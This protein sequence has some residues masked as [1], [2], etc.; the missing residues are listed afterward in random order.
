MR[1]APVYALVGHPVGHSLSPLLHGLMLRLSGRPGT[2]VALDSAE[3][4]G[5]AVVGA[6]R[7][8]GFAG[9]N[10]TIPLKEGA[11]PVVDRRAPSAAR[12]GATNTLV[13]DDK[14]LITAYNTDG[15]G[16]CDA[17]A[18]AGPLPARAA[19]LGAG[20]AARGVAAALGA[21]GVA[22]TLCNRDL[23]RAARAAAALGCAAAP[24]WGE[25]PP[26]EVELVVNCSAD[27][28]LVAEPERGAC[29]LV[30]GGLWVDTNYFR[31]PLG[32]PALVAA[33][34]R[35]QTGHP[36]LL[37][38]ARRAFALLTGG[39]APTAAALRAALVG[40]AWPTDGRG[41]PL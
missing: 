7:T 6:L 40:T 24:S 12:A 23:D 31:A 26:L 41:A 39:P 4:D 8:L 9:A 21:A 22:V 37:H 10:L 35:L 3:A 29:R 32:G 34:R 2:Y 13:I 14:Q 1:P 20:G 18:E 19:V 38:Q 16:L 15:D 27:P 36:M 5:A 28:E 17:V 33:G 25:G 11:L 30:L